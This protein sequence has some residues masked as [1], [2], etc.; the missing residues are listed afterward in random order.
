MVRADQCPLFF[1]LWVACSSRPALLPPAAPGG[2]GGSGRDRRL[3]PDVPGP[4]AQAGRVPADVMEGPRTRLP[5]PSW[6]RV[7]GP[8]PG[9]GSADRTL[10]V[11]V[12]SSL[13]WTP[14]HPRQE[15]KGSPHAVSPRRCRLPLTAFGFCRLLDQ[16]S[17]PQPWSHSQQK[18]SPH[19]RAHS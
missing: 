5:Q 17:L 9:D 14:L 19:P 1:H 3:L 2:I 11:P 10:W 15:L 16:V 8:A 12:P 7:E 18:T 6:G 4:P 13:L